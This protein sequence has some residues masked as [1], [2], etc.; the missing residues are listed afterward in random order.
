MVWGFPL[1]LK[2]KGGQA[3]KPKPVNNARVDKLDGFM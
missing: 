1:V 3:L 2:G